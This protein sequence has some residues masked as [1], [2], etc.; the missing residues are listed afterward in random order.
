MTDDNDKPILTR[1]R[2]LG[3][4]A[5]IGAASAVG[6]G[7][8]AVFNDEE[9]TGDLSFA[10][11]EVDL[12]VDYSFTY[13]YDSSK[14]DSGT[15]DGNAAL[16]CELED[17]KPGDR[18]TIEF[19]PTVETNPA[20]V[21]VSGGITAE[22]ENGF[23]EA[24][25]NDGGAAQGDGELDEKLQARLKYEDGTVIKSKRSLREMMTALSDGVVL[26]EVYGDN[27][28]VPE[29]C[30]I[31]VITLPGDTGNE[32]QSDSVTFDMTFNA[33]QERHN[34]NPFNDG[35]GSTTTTEGS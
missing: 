35:G 1:R 33:E 22:S 12:A 2:V 9:S 20:Y 5:T 3:G 31:L 7:T 32:V 14:D 27:V 26:D 21:Q 17:L 25:S 4:M 13:H 23:N 34:N 19:C 15:I 28:E 8:T 29:P 30:I 18:I 11:G 16:T 24:E 10:A 6:A